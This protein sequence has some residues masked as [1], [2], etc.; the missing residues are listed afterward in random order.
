MIEELTIEV[1][2]ELS[3]SLTYY[4]VHVYTDYTTSA[5][6]RFDLGWVIITC[7]ILLFVINLAN[8]L[9]PAIKEILRKK[10]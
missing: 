7:F 9:I 5:D 2:N 10:C 8:I 3:V 6:A 1:I 4:F